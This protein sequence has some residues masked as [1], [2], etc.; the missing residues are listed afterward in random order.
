[1]TLQDVIKGYSVNKNELPCIRWHFNSG[2]LTIP[3]LG[4]PFIMIGHAQYNCAQGKDNSLSR[5]RRSYHS[6]RDETLPKRHL[7]RP[8]KKLGCPASF[9][10]KKIYAFPEFSL[11]KDTKRNRTGISVAIKNK[12]KLFIEAK[13]KGKYIE[14][15]GV[16]MYLTKEF[17]LTSAHKYHLENRDS[18]K[19]SGENALNSILF[20]GAK[21]NSYKEA[22]DAVDLYREVRNV[23][24][25]CNSDEAIPLNNVSLRYDSLKYVCYNALEKKKYCGK[26]KNRRIIK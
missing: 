6:K 25:Y 5:K 20:L 9:S 7:A 16:L 4:Y 18:F 2:Y 8:T 17:P 3:F 15:L 24:L 14:E 12:I 13:E 26:G 21:F 19:D 23:K 22:V 11:S 1:M 10:V